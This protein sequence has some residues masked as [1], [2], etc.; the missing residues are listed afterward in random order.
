MKYLII[1]IA[2]ISLYYPSISA[3]IGVNTNNPSSSSVLDINAYDNDR[4]LLIPRMNTSQKLAIASPASGLMVYDMDYRCVSQYKDT[5]SNPGTFSWTCLTLY[6]RHFLY[7]P[8][9]NI[10]TSDGSGSLLVGTQSINLYNVY[11]TGFNSPKVKSTS[12]PATIPF[13]NGS[14]LNYYV[15]YCDPCITVTG[16]SEAGVMSYTVN[17]RPNYDAFVNVVFTLK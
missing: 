7:M 14:Q 4:G 1:I 15:T 12:A 8:S 5:P 3:Q 13:F 16:I 9:V 11:Y 2:C 17:S 10:P 6:N